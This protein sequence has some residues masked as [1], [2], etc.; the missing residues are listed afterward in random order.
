MFSTSEKHIFPVMNQVSHLQEEKKLLKQS[1]EEEIGQL[2]TQLESMRTSR[3]ELGGEIY[4]ATRSGCYLF[5]W[6]HLVTHRGDIAD[7]SSTKSREFV[8][9]VSECVF[10][11]TVSLMCSVFSVNFILSQS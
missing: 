8:A 11:V 1:S 9:A 10:P 6:I 7:F 5:F 3:Q 4:S 2:W